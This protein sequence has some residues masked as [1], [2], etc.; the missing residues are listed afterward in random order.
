MLT[1]APLIQFTKDILSSYIIGGIIHLGTG[2]ALHAYIYEV[3]HRKL[4]LWRMLTLFILLVCIG[5][6]LIIAWFRADLQIEFDRPPLTAY[7]I[8][9]F[10]AFLEIGLPALFGFFLAQSWLRMEVAQEE[11]KWAKGLAERI[12]Q[13]DPPHYGWI[14]EAFSIKKEQ[15]GIDQEMPGLQRQYQDAVAHRDGV[16]A[17]D[18]DTKIH[19]HKLRA[20]LLKERF[21]WVQKYYPGGSA[22]LEIEVHRKMQEVRDALNNHPLT[23]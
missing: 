21:D 2:L 19:Q 16:K 10:Q 8:S 1:A 15:W 3:H 13:N 12:P 11:Y 7:L 23:P 6:I 4:R 20:D 18:L 9:A 17:T 22:E 5:A 14:D